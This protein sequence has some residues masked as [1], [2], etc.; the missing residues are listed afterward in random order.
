MSD[1]KSLESLPKVAL[2]FIDAVVKKV[3]YRKKIRQ[4]VCEELTDHFYMALKDCTADE[5]KQRVAEE[6]IDEFGDVKVLASL[7]RRGKK[8]C[9]PLWRT[10]VVRTFQAF[11]VLILFMTLYSAWF[12]SGKPNI[13]T[14]YIEALNKHL[15]P[16]VKDENNAWASYKKAVDLRKDPAEDN[17]FK[18]I[19]RDVSLSITN[20]TDEQREGL[21]KWIDLNEQ[22]WTEFSIAA[23]KP[24][25][26]REYAYGEGI[27]DGWSIHV[28][29]P[30]LHDIKILS[31]LAVWKS[32]LAVEQ[33]NN[34]EALEYC[35]KILKVSKHWMS[36]AMM[37]EYLVGSSVG[38]YG[39]RQAL[40]I[41]NDGRLDPA[42]LK[43]FRNEI[44]AVFSEGYPYC[45]FTGEEMFLLDAIQH[46]FTYG[47][48][49]GGHIAPRPLASILDE[50]YYDAEEV[51][52]FLFGTLAHAGRNKT[53]EKIKEIYGKLDEL[54]RI[55]PYDRHAGNIS[56]DSIGEDLSQ[57]KYYILRVF[58]PSWE[59]VCN[60]K[61]QR[62]CQYQA[63][64]TVLAIKQWQAQHRALPKDLGV[65][66]EAGL[67]GELSNDPYSAGSLVYRVE[68]DDFKLYSFGKNFKD[69]GG[70]PGTYKGKYRLWGDDGDAVFWPVV[71]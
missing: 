7:I 9:R 49:G 52:D 37:I 30:S 1:N 27:K 41:V 67:L 64:L 56:I 50:D 5:E 45:D 47:G 51:R 3:R 38:S 65:L 25:L 8:R 54:S 18:D 14:D 48:P 23:E 55:T 26:H 2:D 58:I 39:C 21:N 68:G 17:E 36:R 33:G 60:Y 11:G 20:L 12:I 4:E 63:V 10:A 34:R 42:E 46:C 61:Y 70:T 13:E 19:I 69:D 57:Y 53:I 59:K 24:Y 35:V 31:R 40:D 66:V 62:G 28:L 32:K 22:A 15:R 6:V 43:V 29:M 16:E 44:S 71:R